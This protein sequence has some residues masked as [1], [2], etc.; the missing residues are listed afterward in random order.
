MPALHLPPKK[1]TELQQFITLLINA[2]QVRLEICADGGS[3]PADILK[4]VTDSVI[5]ARNQLPRN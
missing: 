1:P 4:A 3:T 2:L 5:D